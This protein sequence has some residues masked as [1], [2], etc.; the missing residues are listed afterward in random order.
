MNT[1]PTQAPSARRPTPESL[2]LM[3]PPDRPGGLS[4]DVAGA[5]SVS[6]SDATRRTY[7]GQ[8]RQFVAWADDAGIPW[9]L[10]APV[11]VAEYL[12]A[13]VGA[14]RRSCNGAAR[15]SPFRPRDVGQSEDRLSEPRSR[16]RA[17]AGLARH[18]VGCGRC[19]ALRGHG[20]SSPVR[21]AENYVGQSEDRLSEPRSRSRAGAGLA[22]RPVGC[23]RCGALR[24]H[25]ASSPV[26]SAENLS[27]R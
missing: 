25:G 4:P 27:S 6:R 2:S 1:P 23:G 14:G 13:L 8:W 24:G 20:A 17:G 5:V 15:R 22:R 26:R 18:P 10:T 21:S 16:S 9:L 19:G 3:D 12:T 11:D 7:S